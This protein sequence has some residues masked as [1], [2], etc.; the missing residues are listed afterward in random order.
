MTANTSAASSPR[1]P[2]AATPAAEA[3]K[4][5]PLAL[6]H[7]PKD[8]LADAEYD[9]DALHAPVNGGVPDVRRVDLGLQS[10][11]ARGIIG[12]LGW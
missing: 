10:S 11:T 4:L 7:G 8:T 2:R 9:D 3:E 12:G 1:G 6:P 5:P